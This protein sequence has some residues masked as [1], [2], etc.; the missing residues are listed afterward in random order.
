MLILSSQTVKY[1]ET[2]PAVREAAGTALATLGYGNWKM[3]E[4]V[5]VNR[6]PGGKQGDTDEGIV[7]EHFSCMFCIPTF[8]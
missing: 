2:L 8:E 7:L 1:M 4:G 5:S 6:P 3:G